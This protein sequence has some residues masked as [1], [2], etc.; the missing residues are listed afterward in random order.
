MPCSVVDRA[1]HGEGEACS[2]RR[3]ITA[4][5]GQRRNDVLMEQRTGHRQV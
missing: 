3:M 5:I 1:V 2:Q 4:V